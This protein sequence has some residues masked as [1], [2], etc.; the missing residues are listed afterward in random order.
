VTSATEFTQPMKLKGTMSRTNANDPTY[1]QMEFAC[2]E[3]NE[4]L[5]HYTNDQGGAAKN[6]GGLKQ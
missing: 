2:V 3:G 5:K 4:D 1:E 6:V